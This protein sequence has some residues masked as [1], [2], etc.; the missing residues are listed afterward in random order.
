MGGRGGCPAIQPAAKLLMPSAQARATLPA[1][2]GGCG[3]GPV[4]L[5]AHADVRLAFGSLRTSNRPLSDSEL[6]QTG[7][8]KP[9]CRKAYL[10]SF[11]QKSHCGLR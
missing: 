3:K 1:V 6:R 10:Q 7:L 11:A 5:N 8:S 9:G 2:Q 4:A